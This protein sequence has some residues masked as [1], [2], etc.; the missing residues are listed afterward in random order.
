M[1]TD[2]SKFD[3]TAT[4]YSL[5]ALACWI[6]GPLCIKQLSGWL[7]FWTQNMLR[8]L[9]A[10]FLLLPFLLVSIKQKKVDRLIW[11]NA[12]IITIPNIFMQSLWAAGFYYINPALLTLIAKSSILWTILFS[13]VFFLD[14]RN[15]LKSTRFWT[16]S[17]A[18]II[19]LTG[20]TVLNPTFTTKATLI[21]LVFVFSASFAWS[22]YTVGIKALLANYD[23]RV[24][25]AI[26]SLYT[27]VALT[28]VAVLFGK[29]SDCLSMPP[30][31]WLVIIF[32]ACTSLALSHSFYY[33]AIKRI[34]AT[35][36]SLVTLA[37]PFL[38]LVV[39]RIL[40]AETLTPAQWVCGIILVAGAALAIWAQEHLNKT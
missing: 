36:P 27:T 11:K 24:S 10:A 3:I 32:S 22:I 23:S 18:M 34:G 12:L 20:V 29:P 17:A 40:F 39:S 31:G 19:G 26:V 15:L 25:F 8:Y 30:A 38:V 13:M 7:D 35:I 5:G 9:F 28:I 21:G 6:I 37:Q 1:K 16:A 14:E 2:H 33:A 4:A